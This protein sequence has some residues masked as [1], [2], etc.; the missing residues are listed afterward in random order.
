L[1]K[2]LYIATHKHG[3]V[4]FLMCSKAMFSRRIYRGLMEGVIP[5]LKWVLLFHGGRLT[6]DPPWNGR[7]LDYPS[8]DLERALY[9]LVEVLFRAYI[10]LESFYDLLKELQRR[11]IE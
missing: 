3:Q 5:F 7:T 9:S 8:I 2:G 4:V 6:N 10:S 11:V 1:I